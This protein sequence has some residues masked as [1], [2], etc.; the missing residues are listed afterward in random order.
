MN[1]ENMTDKELGEYLVN[2]IENWLNNL[3]NDNKPENN[4]CLKLI[5]KELKKRKY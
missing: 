5:R 4:R 2:Q 1:N 3:T